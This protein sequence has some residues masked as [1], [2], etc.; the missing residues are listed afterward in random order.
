MT[1]SELSSLIL[2]NRDSI[3]F[4]VGNGVHNYETNTK[5][6]K[7]VSWNKL[8]RRIRNILDV[9]SFN[10]TPIKG[11]SNPEYFDLIELAYINDSIVKDENS[12]RETLS[13][14]IKNYKGLEERCQSISYTYCVPSNPHTDVIQKVAL[15]AKNDRLHHAQENIRQR[16]AYILED[17]GIPHREDITYDDQVFAQ[18]LLGGSK[19][20]Y[21]VKKYI[22]YI[23]KDYSFQDWIK[24]FLQF[25]MSVRAPILTTNYDLALSSVLSLTKRCTIEDISSQYFYPFETYFSDEI[26]EEPWN[27]FGVWHINGLICYPQSIR[28]GHLDYADMLSA[29][30]NRIYVNKGDFQILYPT[31][32]RNSWVSIFFHRDIFIWGLGLNVD[33]YVLRWLLIER[34]RFNIIAKK[35]LKG[36][37]VQISDIDE[38]MKEEKKIFLKSVG[39]DIIEIKN[40]DLHENVWKQIVSKI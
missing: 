20:F 7:K 39:L 10:D 13:N 11:M 22:K 16:A 26:I 33:E 31:I 2:K 15:G 28:I 9:S 27:D 5:G 3:A 12:F 14:L 36:W 8:L 6:I 1:C 21:I 25:V 18:E 24:P 37:Y 23:F 30:R 17:F 40:K 29:I 34:A 32:D 35:N 19:K 38:I 4:L